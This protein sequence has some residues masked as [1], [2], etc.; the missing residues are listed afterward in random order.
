VE[1]VSDVKFKILRQ[2]T[3]HMGRVNLRVQEDKEITLVVREKVSPEVAIDR[4][5]R[6]VRFEREQQAE[7][8]ARRGPHPMF[9][10]MGDRRNTQRLY[11]DIASY[12]KAASN[13]RWWDA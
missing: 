1:E 5:Q 2:W 13:P 11:E 4:Q 10:S 6:E 7:E 3:D 12:M 8:E 9:F